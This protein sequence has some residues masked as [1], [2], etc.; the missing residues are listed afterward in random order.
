MLKRVI[1]IGSTPSSTPGTVDLTQGQ[2]KDLSSNLEVYNSVNRYFNF[3]WM[4]RDAT[5]PHS[6]FNLDQTIVDWWIVAYGDKP[7]LDVSRRNLII[8][9]SYELLYQGYISQ[10]IPMTEKFITNYEASRLLVSQPE[11]A[12]AQFTQTSRSLFEFEKSF[13]DIL[14]LPLN[15]QRKDDI[16]S[17][18]KKNPPKR[19]ADTP[20]G[21]G[22]Q[23]KK[24][25]DLM[26][27]FYDKLME[28]KMSDEQI[29]LAAKEQFKDSYNGNPGYIVICRQN[30][31]KGK[32]GMKPETELE[33]LIDY[34]GKIIPLSSVP[35]E[36]Q[37]AVVREAKKLIKGRTDRPPQGPVVPKTATARK[38]TP[39]KRATPT[40]PQP[41]RRQ[42]GATANPPSTPEGGTTVAPPLRRRVQ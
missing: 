7:P 16:M 30:I 35:P 32:Y 2:S 1:P 26:Q 11:I 40:N 37:D 12:I 4:W 39:M 25:S 41:M 22:V 29:V 33:R 36:E 38:G 6:K 5:L 20:T 9:L 27:F 34:Q 24:M 3:M 17:T 21:E 23:P 14:S 19:K 10:E 8:Q 42:L 31:N 18:S 28:G 13:Q 15:F